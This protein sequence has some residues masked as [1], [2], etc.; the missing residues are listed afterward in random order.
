M[1]KD[2]HPDTAHDPD[3]EEILQELGINELTS[4]PHDATRWGEVGKILFYIDEAEESHPLHVLPEEDGEWVSLNDPDK[5][6]KLF[7][8]LDLAA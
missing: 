1:T 3:A 7:S 5:I 6:R 8:D 2:A 4:N